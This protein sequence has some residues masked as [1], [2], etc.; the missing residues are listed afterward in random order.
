MKLKK[1]LS[2]FKM[3]ST[4]KL[5][6]SLYKNLLENLENINDCDWNNLKR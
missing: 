2:K 5:K 4:K 1:S 6:R 3:R